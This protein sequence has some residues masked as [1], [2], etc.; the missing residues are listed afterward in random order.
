MSQD[1]YDGMTELNHVQEELLKRVDGLDTYCKALRD[2][3]NDLI[4]AVE[5]L[6]QR[7]QDKAVREVVNVNADSITLGAPS[8]GQLKVYGDFENLPVFAGKLRNAIELLKGAKEESA[9]G[10]N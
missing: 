5:R 1:N 10:K 4:D 7:R 2:D 9:A 8:S 6:A 3:V